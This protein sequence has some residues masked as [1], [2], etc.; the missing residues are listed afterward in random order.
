MLP[1]CTYQ[2][3]DDS[4]QERRI[5]NVDPKLLGAVE[6]VLFSPTRLGMMIQSDENI[7]FGLKPPTSNQCGLSPLEMNAAPDDQF[8]LSFSPLMESDSFR[9]D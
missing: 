9:I 2:F 3:N 1:E 8:W 4:L 5:Q 7:F 6:H